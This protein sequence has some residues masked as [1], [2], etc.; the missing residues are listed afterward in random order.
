MQYSILFPDSVSELPFPALASALLS[1]TFPKFSPLPLL[2]NLGSTGTVF[3][4]LEIREI[5][6]RTLLPFVNQ[7]GDYR[8]PVAHQL[9]KA[10]NEFSWFF[11]ARSD[12][13]FM[14]RPEIPNHPVVRELLFDRI[15]ALTS[16]S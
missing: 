11:R 8:A 14:S 7:H 6:A 4:L 1:I 15:I 9:A 12:C 5:V 13:K 10:K 3:Q 16:S 2:P